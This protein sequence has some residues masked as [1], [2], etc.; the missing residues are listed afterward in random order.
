MKD[1]YCIVISTFETIEQA[2]PVIDKVLDMKLAA[3]IQTINIGSHY[4]WNGS[5]CHDKEI[6]VLFKTSTT[7]YDSLKSELEIL[8][9]YDTPEIIRISIEDGAAAYL[10]WIDDVTK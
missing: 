7:L 6:L 10:K 1:K 3:C 8:H 4:S 2:Q 9:P 5:L